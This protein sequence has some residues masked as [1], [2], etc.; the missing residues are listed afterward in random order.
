[1]TKV[2]HTFLLMLWL[3]SN[4]YAQVSHDNIDYRLALQLDSGWVHSSTHHATVE[5]SCINKALTSKCLIYHNDQWFVIKP[6]VT[7][8]YYINI[9]TGRCKDLRGIQATI[10]EGHPC[11]IDTYKILHCI[12]QIRED[13]VF[14]ALDSV[15]A[16]VS[17]LVNIDGFLGDF[18]DFRI[19][20]SSQAKGVPVNPTGT[21]ILESDVHRQDFI[22]TLTWSLPDTLTLLLSHFSLYRKHEADKSSSLLMTVPLKRNALG[23]AEKQYHTTDTLKRNGKYQYVIYGNAVGEEPVLL[24][25]ETL[26]YARTLPR[27]P[28]KAHT[29]VFPFYSPKAGNVQVS[30]YNSITEKFLASVSRK[31]TKGNNSLV[32]DL[33]SLVRQRIYFYKVVVSGNSVKEQRYF[34]FSPEKN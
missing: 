7:G 21:G 26:V 30:I 27:S 29:I 1:M 6:T 4:G 16:G 5:W 18:C 14:I 8:K 22:V 11:E 24:V 31:V 15:S 19:A 12:P 28:L 32:L 2:Y 25:K 3:C 10:I 33:S 17:Y 20:F 23:I 9:S 13:D 34:S